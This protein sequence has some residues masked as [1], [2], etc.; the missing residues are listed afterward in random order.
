[1]RT[2]AALLLAGLAV[3]GCDLLSAPERPSSHGGAD[4][5]ASGS[6]G[7]FAHSQSEDLSGYYQA[8]GERSRGQA[9]LAR[10]FIGQARDFEAWEAG[11]R[12][13]G[14]A[15]IL[16][17][18]ERADGGGERVLPDSYSVSDGRVRMSGTGETLGRVSFDGRLNTGSLATARRN[19]GEGEEPVMTGVATIAG[20][21]DSGLKLHWYGGD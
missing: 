21:S 10:V 14:F 6:G 2:V 9:R 1:M 13:G 3:A 4:A 11:K 19:L 20:R 8:A 12:S 17:E 18:F 7:S 16:L 15:P 5:P